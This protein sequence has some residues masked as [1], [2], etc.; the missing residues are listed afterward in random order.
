MNTN[1]TKIDLFIF[2]LNKIKKKKTEIF[3]YFIK[4][5]F[6]MLKVTNFTKNKIL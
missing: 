5:L 1:F 6:L 2:F 4:S 3:K